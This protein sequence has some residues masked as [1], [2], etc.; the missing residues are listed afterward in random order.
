MK[1]ITEARQTE[2]ARQAPPTVWILGP[3]PLLNSLLCTY[4]DQGSDSLCRVAGT[5]FGPADVV[6]GAAPCLLLID[7]VDK[8]AAQLRPFCCR[9]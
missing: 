3:N 9:F 4:L 5:D 7:F 1:A 2:R 8:S 6:D